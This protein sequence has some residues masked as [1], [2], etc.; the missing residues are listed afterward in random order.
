MITKGNAS[1]N[2][3]HFNLEDTSKSWKIA[4]DFWWE[5]FGLWHKGHGGLFGWL[6]LKFPMGSWFLWDITEKII[7]NFINKHHQTHKSCINCFGKKLRNTT[8]HQAKIGRSHYG[9]TKPIFKTKQN[10]LI[11][12]INLAFIF[13]VLYAASISSHSCLLIFIWC[14]VVLQCYVVSFM[15]LMLFFVKFPLLF[16]AICHKALLPL[17]NLMLLSS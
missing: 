4:K 14:R 17:W 11:I 12:L 2:P 10:S 13:S 7:G 3:H 5:N 15:H 1:D 6:S 9:K 8:L 16:T